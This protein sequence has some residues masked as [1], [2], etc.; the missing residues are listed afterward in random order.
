MYKLVDKNF[1][2]VYKK[3]TMEGWL[4]IRKTVTSNGRVVIVTQ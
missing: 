4:A 3:I 2:Y 1:K